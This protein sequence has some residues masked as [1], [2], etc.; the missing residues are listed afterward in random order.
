MRQKDDTRLI[1]ILNK[2]RVGDVNDA[3]ESLIKS[4]LAIPREILY[5]IDTLHLF[6]QND[7]GDPQNTFMIN[8]LNSECVFI[9]LEASINVVILETDFEL[10]K[11][12]L[13][14]PVV[15]LN[16]CKQKAFKHKQVM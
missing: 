3:L 4:I 6:A 14:K 1:A 2:I 10:I 8:Q 5:P 12:G 15:S 7:T 13:S 9:K 16:L 11:M